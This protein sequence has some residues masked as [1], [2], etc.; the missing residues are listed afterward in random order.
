MADDGDDMDIAEDFSKYT[1]EKAYKRIRTAMK[2]V[3]PRMDFRYDVNAEAAMSQVIH[4]LAAKNAK[5]PDKI[6]IYIN[7]TME[8]YEL[9]KDEKM[10]LQNLSLMISNEEKK[11]LYPHLA[12]YQKMLK[13]RE[14]VLYNKSSVT[15]DLGL[16]P[17]L[18]V[19][20]SGK[21][22]KDRLKKAKPRSVGVLNHVLALKTFYSP[23][24]PQGD[25]KGSGSKILAD[26]KKML[27]SMVI[28]TTQKAMVEQFVKN[29][30]QSV[31]LF[32]L[33]LPFIKP[34]TEN[35]FALHPSVL[36]QMT[37]EELVGANYNGHWAWKAMSSKRVSTVHPGG[38]GES[39]QI[40]THMF[41]SS[42]YEDLEVLSWVLGTEMTCRQTWGKWTKK[43]DTWEVTE[44]AF[45]T[46]YWSRPQRGAPRSLGVGGSS[47]LCSVQSLRGA[48]PAYNVNATAEQ[49]MSR[50]VPTETNL[51]KQ[52][53]QEIDIYKALKTEGTGEFFTYADAAAT[54]PVVCPIGGNG[55]FF[56][57]DNRNGPR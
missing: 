15:G 2:A 32:G 22:V 42:N 41:L 39:G 26:R 29:D 51:Y 28:G 18:E 3:F 49:L 54:T 24:R 27:R 40:I 10:A 16:P 17:H 8:P 43:P 9:S 13:T 31:N 52:T 5:M 23:I 45:K 14:E 48:R 55:K 33:S 20:A 47:Q 53:E 35:N 50:Y 57:A 36:M 4:F 7:G 12:V 38:F 1:P 56:Y 34:R 19:F 21:Y 11:F 46:A 44:F 30:F 25:M 37:D 6:T